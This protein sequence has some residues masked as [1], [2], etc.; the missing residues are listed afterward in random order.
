MGHSTGFG[1]APWATAQN[2]L[3]A[4]GDRAGSGSTLWAMAPFAAKQINT[5][6]SQSFL[7]LRPYY[8][9]FNTLL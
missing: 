6:F 1:Y 5:P 3:C 7:L 2:S 9:T 8:S 4:M